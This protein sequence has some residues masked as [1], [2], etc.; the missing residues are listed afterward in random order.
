MQLDNA[1]KNITQTKESPI[2]H[3]GNYHVFIFLLR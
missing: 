1:T 2:L 3:I